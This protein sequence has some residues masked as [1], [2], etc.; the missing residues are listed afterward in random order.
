MQGARRKYMIFQGARQFIGDCIANYACL[1]VAEDG[2]G[3]EVEAS[4]SLEATKVL[5]KYR[6]RWKEW[7][8]LP[9]EGPPIVTTRDSYKNKGRGVQ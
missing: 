2:P 7:A 6:E 5:G 4:L 1:H 3:Q 8:G 9:S